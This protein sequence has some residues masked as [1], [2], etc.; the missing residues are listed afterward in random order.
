MKKLLVISDTHGRH[1]PIAVAVARFGDIDMV[2]H[3]GDYSKDAAQLR[4]MTNKPVYAVRGNCDIASTEEDE[5]LLHIEGVRVLMLHGH[6][7]SVKTS[8]LR[9]GLYAHEKEAKLALFGHTHVPA[10]RVY[11][12][13]R[14]YN[15]GSLGEP[16]GRKPS[17]GL[18]TLEDGRIR[19]K[20]VFL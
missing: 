13:V 11:S 7:Q 3:L 20:T 6:K 14:L 15:P 2:I 18:V 5:Q 1:A 8:L 16:R 12:G 17:V 4:K 19:I 10:E 9:L